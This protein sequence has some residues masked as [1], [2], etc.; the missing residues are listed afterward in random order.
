MNVGST[1]SDEGETADSRITLRI[2]TTRRQ[3]RANPCRT[4]ERAVPADRSR[5]PGALHPGAVRGSDGS[6][7]TVDR[8]G[9]AGHRPE[10]RCERTRGATLTITH[11]QHWSR[12]SLS[13]KDVAGSA[14]PLQPVRVQGIYRAGAGT[15]LRVQRWEG[16]SGCPFPRRLTRRGSSPLMSNLVSQ[17]VTA[18]VSWVPIRCDVQ[19][20]CSSDRRL[21]ASGHQPRGPRSASSLAKTTT[22]SRYLCLAE[23]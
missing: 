5:E 21:T 9:R 16:G 3:S 7:A 1:R 8:R 6:G 15:F 13:L 18:F 11:H 14:R 22:L 4:L 23:S 10:R 17:V 20:L 12:S 19:N 2:G